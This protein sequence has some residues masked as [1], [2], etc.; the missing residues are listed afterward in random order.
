MLSLLIFSADVFLALLQL[1][2]SSSDANFTLYCLGMFLFE[3]SLIYFDRSNFLT[4]SIF[5][6]T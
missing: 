2:K 6:P 5:L 1:G 4:F 3:N